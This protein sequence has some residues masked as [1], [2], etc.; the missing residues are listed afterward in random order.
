VQA[1]AFCAVCLKPLCGDCA[2]EAG[3]ECFCDDMHRAYASTHARIAAVASPFEADAV[4]AN[5]TSN[6]IESRLFYFREHASVVLSNGRDS[7]VVFVPREKSE[8]AS[9]VLSSLELL[10]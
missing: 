3:G 8:E 6:G 5:L 1:A 2:V 9:R 7:A 10:S 4:V